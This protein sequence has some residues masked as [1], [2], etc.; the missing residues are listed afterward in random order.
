M[1]NSRI[2]PQNAASVVRISPSSHV[3]TSSKTRIEKPTRE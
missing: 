1:S 2:L 3:A